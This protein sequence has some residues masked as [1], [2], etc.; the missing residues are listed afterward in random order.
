MQTVSFQ[1]VFCAAARTLCACSTDRNAQRLRRTENYGALGAASRAAGRNAEV[2]TVY[3]QAIE[4]NPKS[5]DAH[6]ALGQFYFSLDKPDEAEAE[7]RSAYGLDARAVRPRF[8]QARLYAHTGR[9]SERGHVAWKEATP[10][11]PQACSAL[12]GFYL[13]VGRRK[14][15]IAEFRSL[16]TEHHKDNSSKAFLVRTLLDL[17]HVEE[18]ARMNRKTLAANAMEP[19]ALLAEGR[20]LTAS[21]RHTQAAEALGKAVQV[22]PHSAGAFS[23]LGVAQQSAGLAD[24][25]Q[26]SFTRALQLRP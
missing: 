9:L 3:R 17:N 6:V 4:V 2:E 26:P 1:R 7:L 5:V 15:A 11:D 24:S 10:D 16:L 19:S 18:A 22:S 25:A 8:F 14:D 23:L 12:G 13:S 21:C 20:I